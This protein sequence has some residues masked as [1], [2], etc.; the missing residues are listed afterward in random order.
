MLDPISIA[1][2]MPWKEHCEE[3][4]E[5]LMA[6]LGELTFPQDSMTY[7]W[8]DSITAQLFLLSVSSP[9]IVD[10]PGLREEI[11]TL[12][13]MV[14]REVEGLREKVGNVLKRNADALDTKGTESHG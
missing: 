4:T 1:P 3:A 14:I 13:R 2:P 11:E 10:E 5:A 7:D 6:A 12:G 9:L 8:I